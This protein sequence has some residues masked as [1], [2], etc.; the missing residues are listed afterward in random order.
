MACSVHTFP[1]MSAL[2]PQFGLT[3]MVNHACNLRCTYCYTGG[4]FNAPMPARIA[5]AAINRALASLVTSGRLELSFFG[6]EPLIESARILEWMDYA[7]SR[8]QADGKQVRFNVTTNGTVT[9]RDAWRVMMSND[10]DVAVSFDGSPEMHDRHRRDAQGQGSAAAVEA[11]LRQLIDSGKQVRVNAVVR[12]DT[13]DQLPDGLI[14]LHDLGI[15]QVDLS[16]DLWT[17]WTVGDGRR[18]EHVINRAAELWRAWLPEFALNWFDVKAGVLAGI[19][20]LHADT[21]CSF[22][23]GEIS[24]APSGR[25]Y[26]CERLIGEDRPGHPLC[27]PGHVMD[28]NDFLGFK[29]TPFKTCDACSDCILNPVCD[30]GCRCSNFVRSGDVN[31]PDGLLCI[32]NK[33][34]AAAVNEALQWI[35][36]R[37]AE[38]HRSQETACYE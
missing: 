25:L 29:V 30:T 9:H 18:L 16:L 36:P 10:L 24:V 21:R 5:L 35:A 6:G 17:A 8:A 7:R 3:L 32:L 27:L 26:P 4:K 38:S 1:D 11:T 34:T 33:A 37:C 31:R 28:G 13:L 23:D 2:R 15:R 14:Y 22:G 19:P 12:P 20:F